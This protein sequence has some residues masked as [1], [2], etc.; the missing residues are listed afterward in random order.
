[1]GLK[2][3]QHHIQLE[4]SI[5]DEDTIGSQ[6]L[7][8]LVEKAQQSV[9][10]RLILDDFGSSKLAKRQTYYEKKGIQFEIFMQVRYSSLA[11]SNYRNHRKII[12][13]DGTVGYVGGINISDKY[14]NPNKF[15][16]YWRDT[17]VRFE[18]D[19]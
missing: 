12:V 3:A 2:S 19:S 18:G 11:N 10:A 8:L 17:S 4:Y 9:E 15:N 5:L 14:I 7:D 1:T 16:L 6:I 13:I